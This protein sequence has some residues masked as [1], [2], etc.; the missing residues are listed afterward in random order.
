MQFTS[1]TSG[2]NRNIVH[3]IMMEN[4]LSV[5]V[6]QTSTNTMNHMAEKMEKMV[7]AVKTTAWGGKHGS[8]ALVLDNADYRRLTR[9]QSSTT[10][11]LDPLTATEKAG[12]INFNSTPFEIRTFKEAQ[13]SAIRRTRY[14]RRSRILSWSK[15]LPALTSSKSR[16]STKSTLDTPTAPSKKC[17]IISGQHDTRS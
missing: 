11:R 13:K 8:L 4:A 9:D 5:I 15:S 14:R 12:T 7:A 10:D 16:S 17:Y 6:W 3:S 2:T 1:K